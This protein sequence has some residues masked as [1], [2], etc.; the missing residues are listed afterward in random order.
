[1]SLI[2]NKSVQELRNLRIAKVEWNDNLLFA[3]TLND[4]QSC[5]RG[6]Y[7]F[8]QWWNLQLER[9]DYKDA[10]LTKSHIF[11]PNKKITKIECIIKK[12]KLHFNRHITMRINFYH[13]EEL[14]VAIGDSDKWVLRNGGR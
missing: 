11:D 6:P 1:M 3:F 8:H 7:N 4:S 13:K 9:G 12:W 5:S 14:L 2:V 10:I